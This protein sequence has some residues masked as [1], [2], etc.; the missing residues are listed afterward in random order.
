MRPAMS[1]RRAYHQQGQALVLGLLLAGLASVALF[2]YF[3]VG[4][5]VT[6]K[7]RQHHA[8]DAA[9]YSGA[10][11]QAR[12]MNMISYINRAHVGHQIA[13]AHLVTLGSLA[14]FGGMQA[15]Q[16]SVGNPPVH[17][18]LMLFGADHGAA[19][20]SS[21]AASGLETFATVQGELAKVY[22]KHNA[23]VHDVLTS[24]QEAVVSGLQASRQQAIERIL[25]ANFA[26]ADYDLILRED[27]WPGYVQRFSAQ[28]KLR[29]FIEDVAG[30]YGFLKPRNHTAR[31]SWAVQARCPHKRHELRRRGRTE[32]DVTG[33][34]QSIDTQSFHALRSNRSI[35]CYF[36]E[37]A[38][39]WGWIPSALDP[40]FD[41]PH[42]ADPP[43]NFAA[44]DFWRWVKEAT[45][46]DIISG[47]ANPMADSKAV[48]SRQRWPS[49]GLPAFFDVSESSASGIGFSLEL[50]R[51]GPDGVRITTHSSAET[52]FARPQ[53]RADGYRESFNLFHPYWQARLASRAVLPGSSGV[54]P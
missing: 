48:A 36:R 43:A 35:G 44:Q 24:V 12:A 13:M 7:A 6:A 9:A 10:L 5:V 42:V 31:N 40:T 45:N 30:R 32:L 53:P 51:N 52:F 46:W 19:Y 38:M 25:Q 8:L 28:Q 3:V 11:I 16:R 37:Y 49:G 18:I 41:S 27:A 1:A 50:K 2:R 34:W 26:D 33:R 15:R 47:D 22:S 14:H 4:Q 39:G 17:L 23:I 29:P 54:R 21:S 20:Q